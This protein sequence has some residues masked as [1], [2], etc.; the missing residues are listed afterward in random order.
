MIRN[1]FRT[2]VYFALLSLAVAGLLSS[3]A[4]S[5]TGAPV[6]LTASPLITAGIPTR[7]ASRPPITTPIPP[8]LTPSVPTP[9]PDPEICSPLDGITLE[10]L[11]E[12]I[13]NP[14]VLPQPGLDDGHHGVDLA[15]YRFK[16]QVGMAGLPIH[17][18]L[19]GRVAGKINDRPPYGN[20]V[21]IETPIDAFPQ[22]WLDRLNLPGIGPFTEPQPA[23]NCPELIDIG[24][25]PQ[26]HASLYLLY[27]HMQFPTQLLI[28]DRVSCGQTIGLVGTTGE[29]VNEHL[30]LETRIGPAGTRFLSM[31]YYDT[32]Q[33]KSEAQAYCTWRVSNLFHLFDPMTLLAE[34]GSTPHRAP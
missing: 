4:S 19:A 26:Q 11:P 28:E 1:L 2:Q 9:L 21:I 10:E 33:T 3:C 22:S 14:F 18:V 8:T 30:H 32:G 20:A 25:T 15:F 6:D 23:M 27:A 13:S 31:A 5:P 17:S 16:N 24:N 7:I 29:S 34:N 12:I